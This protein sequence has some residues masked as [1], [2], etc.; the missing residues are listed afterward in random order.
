MSVSM[1]F[2]IVSLPL[3]SCST[4]L[5]AFRTTAGALLRLSHRP[6]RHPPRYIEVSALVNMPPCENVSDVRRFLGM[7]NQLGCF[8]SNLATLSQP[9]RDLLVKHNALDM[10]TASATCVR[11]D[12]G[13]SQRS[14]VLALYSPNRETCAS[15]DASSF[16]LGAVLTQLQETGELA[17]DSFPVTLFDTNRAALLTD[18]E[19][20]T[21]CDMG[22]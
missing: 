17:L 2:S 10:G 4:A 11:Q 19:R 20:S 16:G 5:N 3:A 9:L 7:A 6:N 12:Q 1:Q 22:M 14:H 15:A 18:R 8:P 21:R 13:R